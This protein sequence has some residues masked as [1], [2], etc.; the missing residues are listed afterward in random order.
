MKVKNFMLFREVKDI[1]S[2]EFD[3]FLEIY[4]ISFP[5]V[6]KKPIEKIIEMFNKDKNYHLYVAKD[7][8]V[9]GFSLLYIFPDLNIGLL[10]YM[11]VIPSHQRKGVGTDLFKYTFDKFLSQLPNSLGLLLEIQRED[12]PDL[13]E[14]KIRSDRIRFYAKLGVKVLDGVH[15]LLP[16][17][18][19][20]SPEDMYLMILPLKEMRSLSK[21]TVLQY[22]KNIYLKIYQYEGNDLLD[23]TEK[24]ISVTIQ[25]SDID[26]INKSSTKTLFK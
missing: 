9:I 3:Q 20:T 14:R 10:D 26:T 7:N 11:A 5:P 1:T 13:K 12:V 23:V 6:E 2:V 22:I 18:H 4:S 15:Y 19:G 17:Q 8:S 24:K 21:E 16:P 25:I